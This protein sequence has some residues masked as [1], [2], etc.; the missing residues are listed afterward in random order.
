MKKEKVLPK[1]DNETIKKYKDNI[2]DTIKKERIARGWTQEKLGKII[3]MKGKQISNYE[4]GITTPPIEVLF[5][6]CNAFDCELGYLL[7]DPNY[8]DGTTLKTAIAENTGL[9]KE[10]IEAFDKIM[11]KYPD[12]STV[13]LGCESDRVHKIINDLLLSEFFP[14][15][16]EQMVEL[17]RKYTYSKQLEE[18]L[19]KKYSESILNE[20]YDLYDNSERYLVETPSKE[21][22]KEVLEAYEEICKT[23]SQTYVNDEYA[24]PVARYMLNKSFESLIDN[25]YPNS[26]IV[27]KPHREHY[28]NSNKKTNN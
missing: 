3:S 24:V 26:Q 4:H 11:A 5:L 16:I 12:K 25:I 18:K 8:S 2:K 21:P 22:S 15:L 10:A 1:F 20:A 6:L 28:I 14:T 19:E 17:E 27:I 7:G 23:E 9:K 13:M